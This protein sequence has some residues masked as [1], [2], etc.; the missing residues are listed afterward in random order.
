MTIEE[1]YRIAVE[2]LQ[3]IS[4]R[5]KVA[6]KSPYRNEWIEADA[7][8]DMDRAAW[9]CLKRLDEDVLLPSYTKKRERSENT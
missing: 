6:R 8:R 9:E 3:A 4:T 2:T 1:K 5:A 7:M